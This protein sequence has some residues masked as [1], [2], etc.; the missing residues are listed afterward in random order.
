MTEP[1]LPPPAGTTGLAPPAPAP[2]DE[3]ASPR[4][5]GLSPLFAPAE[6][7]DSGR[8]RMGGLSPLFPRG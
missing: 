3:A 2:L 8:L 4:L 7:V 5:G 6:V 1:M